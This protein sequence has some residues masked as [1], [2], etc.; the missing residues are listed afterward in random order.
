MDRLSQIETFV[1]VAEAGSIGRAAERMNLAKSAVSRRLSA[2]E[3]RLGTAL[4]VR[5]PRAQSLT[6]A[7]AAFYERARG[8]LDGLDEAEAVA[9]PGEDGGPAGLVRMAAPMSFGQRVLLP[10]LTGFLDANAGVDLD[11]RLTDRRVDLVAEGIDMAVR[12]GD[13]ADTQIVARRLSSF[14][15]SVCASPAYL[16]RHGTP[17]HPDDLT[18]GHAGLAST[19]LP[20]AIYW[21]FHTPDGPIDCRPPTR[22]R[23]N[24]GD[25]VR[26]AAIAG[27]GIC[28]VPRF[29]TAAAVADGRLV[30]VLRDFPLR[31]ETAHLLFP[32]GRRM[33]PQV[34]ALADALVAGVS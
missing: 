14:E 10:A 23:A 19:N 9:M 11:L 4:L 2:L 12:L 8:L 31:T 28:V 26:D 1:H 32:P 3:A 20:E 21:T 30:E 22:L 5:S 17:S 7:G 24:N 25:A 27:L 13:L 6:V 16:K 33:A 18:A 34:R 15:R 29:I